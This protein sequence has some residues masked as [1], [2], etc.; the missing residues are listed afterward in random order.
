MNRAVTSAD[1]A[2]AVA[3]QREYFMSHETRDV[4]FRIEQL[5]KLKKAV[6]KYED[7]LSRAL[8]EDL[9][10]ARFEAYATEIGFVL[11]ELSYH[12]HHLKKWVKP[13]RIRTDLVNFYSRSYVVHEPFGVAL[14]IAP[15]NYPFQLLV[16]PLIGAISAGNCVTL[17]PAHYSER[18]TEVIR[19]LIA[20]TFEERYITVFSGGREV[21]QSLL[22]QRFDYIFFTGSPF[23][24][25]IV[26]EKAARHLTP[27][28][29]ELGGKSPC[30]VEDD[31]N[32]EVAARRIVF[33]KFLNAGQTC[34]APDYLLVNRRVK[35]KLVEKIKKCIGEFYGDDP[36]TSPDFGRIIN[37]DQFARLAKL[38]ATGTVIF[39][40]ET[41]EGERYIQPTL[42]DNVGPGDPIMQEEIFGPILPII[43]YGDLSEAADF[44]N[45][46][47]KPLAF[48]FFTS[49]RKKER[50]LLGRTSSGGGCVNDT[51]LHLTNPRLPFGG[52]GT[53][54]M[55][56]YHGRH[57][58]DTFSH[59]RSMLAKTTLFDIRLRYAPYRDKLKYAKLLFR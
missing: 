52:V 25:K 34:I 36:R 31:A 8:K 9:G 13:A 49:S 16:D 39:G 37:A 18:T 24:G 7:R 38:L 1:P 43:E 41:A 51:M 42:F 44:V 47:E 53:S 33:G 55:G 46:R 32:L 29:L 14:I 30:I 19:E 21:I 11:E 22:D 23:L 15:W 20:E 54:G 10:K 58:F 12:I 3:A 59:H 5:K 4:T 2:A 50:W 17:K 48:Y 6:L 27:V 45:G 40:G 56:A 26:M 28:S 35:K 57:S